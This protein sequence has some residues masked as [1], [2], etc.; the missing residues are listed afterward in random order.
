MQSLSRSRAVEIGYAN[1]GEVETL[2]DLGERMHDETAYAFLPYDRGK[3][4]RVIEA[5]LA[6]PASACVL[7]ARSENTPV[8]MLVGYLSVYDFCD[9]TIAS[10]SVIYV[11]PEFRSWRA[12][13]GLIRAFRDWAAQRGAREVCLGVSSN[14]EV[15]RTTKLY[16]RLGLTYIGGTFKQRLS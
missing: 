9:E 5:Y 10:D 14:V 15:A 8:G 3:V 7:V 12:A 6:N 2:I 1:A 13:S 11:L 16:E 4:R